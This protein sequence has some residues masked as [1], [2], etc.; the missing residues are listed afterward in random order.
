MP[1]L[2]TGEPGCGKSQL[3][4][5]LA[6]ELDHPQNPGGSWQKPHTFTVKSDTQSRDL[7]YHFDTLGRFRASRR[8]GDNDDPRRFLRFEALGVA[9]LQA[10]G[11]SDRRNRQSAARGAERNRTHDLRYSRAV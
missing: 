11:R 4:Y 6:W 10:L 9:I 8:D 1:L 7:F 2:L 5:S 3:A